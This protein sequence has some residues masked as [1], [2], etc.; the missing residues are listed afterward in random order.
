MITSGTK[1][2]DYRILYYQRVHLRRLMKTT[3]LTPAYQ[4]ARYGRSR[5][6]NQKG[7]GPHTNR[8]SN[9]S[10]RGRHIG[11]QKRRRRRRKRKHVITQATYAGETRTNT[12]ILLYETLTRS[13]ELIVNFASRHLLGGEIRKRQ[14]Q[15]DLGGNGP[16]RV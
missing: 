10:Q 9:M 4:C 7:K 2:Q 6:C 1:I 16:R 12:N 5:P 8:K 14:T 15:P 13:V 11:K 3:I